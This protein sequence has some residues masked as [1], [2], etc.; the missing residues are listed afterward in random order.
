M[1]KFYVFHTMHILV[2]NISTKQC[3]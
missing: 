3:T 2:I 1:T